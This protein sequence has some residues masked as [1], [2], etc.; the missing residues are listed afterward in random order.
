MVYQQGKTPKILLYSSTRQASP[1][2][3][4][5]FWRERGG[6]AKG[7]IPPSF[8]MYHQQKWPIVFR[9]NISLWEVACASSVIIFSVMSIQ[10]FFLDPSL[11]GATVAWTPS[12]PPLPPRKLQS[13]LLGEYR[14]FS[15]RAQ[16]K[17]HCYLKLN[18][19]TYLCHICKLDPGCLKGVIWK[20]SFPWSWEILFFCYSWY[21]SYPVSIILWA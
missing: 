19:A 4:G 21:Y 10:F 11:I 17:T 12:P 3:R 14:I 8:L 13:L 5:E 20:F 16:W 1:L 15:G 9:V 2:A 18:A 6:G 7:G